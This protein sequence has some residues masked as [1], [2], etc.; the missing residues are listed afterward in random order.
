MKPRRCSV[1]GLPWDGSCVHDDDAGGRPPAPPPG[2]GE[3]GSRKGWQNA[4][5]SKR[6][7]KRRRRARGRR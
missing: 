4:N 6:K 5:G 7:D 2:R 1:C 3:K